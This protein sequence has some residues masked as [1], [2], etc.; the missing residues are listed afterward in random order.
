M[1]SPCESHWIKG[2]VSR[3]KLFN[4]SMVNIT[5]IALHFDGR[6]PSPILA[7]EFDG[8]GER[9]ADLALGSH[10]CALLKA[11]VNLDTLYMMDIPSWSAGFNNLL[12]HIFRECAW[13]S[14]A[15]LR[16]TRSCDIKLLPVDP[17]D[18]GYCLGWY[19]FLQKDLDTFLLRH[20]TNLKRLELVKIV[21]LDEQIPPPALSLQYIGDA[22]PEDPTPSLSALEESLKIWSRQLTELEE[23]DVVV[24]TELYGGSTEA[25][26][27]WL[28]DSEIQALATTLGVEPESHPYEALKSSSVLPSR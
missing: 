28:R 24:G 2:L 10:W 17:H 4:D 13:S 15:E 11:A 12:H 18:F 21:G 5:R 7:A 27:T 3:P 26:D 6:R 1:G 23:I 19:L 9:F 25:V 20:R 16:I 22:F 14:L 8:S